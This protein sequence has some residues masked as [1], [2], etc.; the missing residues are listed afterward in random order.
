MI[1]TILKKQPKKQTRVLKKNEEFQNESSSHSNSVSV[2]RAYGGVTD[3][4]HIIDVEN[5]APT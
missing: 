3:L 1:D 4:N 5:A 2:D